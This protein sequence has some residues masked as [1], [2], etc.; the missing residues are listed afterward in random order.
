M[1][2]IYSILSA[3]VFA[4]FVS[5]GA[6]AQLQLPAPSPKATLSQMVGLTEISIEYSS[7]GVKG[8]TIFG[9]LVPYD[10]VWRTG[11]NAS[12]KISFSKDVTIAGTKVAK[13]TYSLLSIPGK[14]DWSI[15]INKDADV[16]VP[17]YKQAN[18][19]VRVSAKP[20]NISKRERLSFQVVD[21]EDS[22]AIVNLEW[23][24]TRVSFAVECATDEQALENIKNSLG[25]TWRT[26][27]SAARY[28]LDKNDYETALKY[29]N[30]SLQLSEEWFNTW[31]KASIL[32]KM[33]KNKEAY[34]LASKAKT[35]GDKNP[36]GFFFKTQV[37]DALA[38]WPKQ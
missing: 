3:V 29:A 28:M 23:D 12:T 6:Y 33:K 32:S 15:I 30:Q 24:Q 21:F 20:E 22:R 11:A 8:R 37:E 5:G 10:Q 36:D 18:D 34:E 27:N 7:P 19:V 2:K 38:T 16:S 26:Y 4:V 9:D 13:G 14:T 25:G 17:D 31:V 1:K 35:L